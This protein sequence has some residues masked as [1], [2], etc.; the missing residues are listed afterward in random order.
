[1]Y[2]AT[3]LR[4]LHSRCHRAFSGLLDHL[5]TLPADVAAREMEGFSYPSLLT[6]AHHV[7]GAEHYWIGVLR[8][9]MPTEEHPEDWASLDAVL[10]YRDRVL[11]ATHA[12]LDATGEA[13]LNAT[14]PLDTWSRKQVPLVPARVVLRTQTHLFHHKGE[15]HAMCRLLGH[16]APA[17]LDFPLD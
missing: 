9:E 13:E 4:D 7:I 3:A 17:R 15:M 12:Y 10:A 16:P 14:V 1:M 2:T 6:Q 5:A 8:G 11:A